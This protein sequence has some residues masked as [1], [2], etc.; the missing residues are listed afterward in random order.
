MPLTS[1]RESL[2]YVQ[3]IRRS[4][5]ELLRDDLDQFLLNYALLE[6][7]KNFTRE[8]IAYPFVE[9]REFKPRAR[10]NNKEY[11]LQNNFLVMFLEEY[12][13][14]LDKKYIRFFN[15]NK[16]TKSNM[17]F[18]RH[19][20]LDGQFDRTIKFVENVR[21]KE[22]M[23]DLLKVDY[24]LLIQRDDT[25]RS[26]ERYSLSHFHV[27]VDW[28][29]TDA[30]E[31]LGKYLRYISKDL[32]EKG[33]KYAEDVQ[34]KFFEYYNVPT[35]SGGRRTAAIV[36]ARYLEKIPGLKT[37]YV[38]SSETRT[39]LK[40]AERGVSRTGIIR[41]SPEEVQ[42]LLTEH[43]MSATFFRQN[44]VIDKYHK[45]FA[46]ILQVMYSHTLP[47]YPPEDGRLRELKSDLNWLTVGREYILPLPGI[48]K[49]EPLKINYT[50][51]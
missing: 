11:E 25:A 6:S 41:L 14:Q 30:A 50:Y 33:D 32:F 15:S 44:Y 36:A 23:T 31:D 29:I 51:T 27:K 20:P 26:S 19:L 17:S 4:Y 13:G 42:K 21:F 7:Y 12:L 1:F 34:K 35:M 48:V 24:G 49:P 37:I 28:P 45:D 46:C 16:V 9:K 43:Q 40:I 38:S 10:I 2:S 3:K 5:Y 47:A 8:R 22:L 18:M 39:L